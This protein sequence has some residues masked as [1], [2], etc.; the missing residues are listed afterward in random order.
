MKII[1]LLLI[2]ILAVLS[3]GLLSTY[4]GIISFKE[5]DDILGQSF[6]FNGKSARGAIAYGLA[7]TGGFSQENNSQMNSYIK[8]EFV[9]RLPEKMSLPTPGPIESVDEV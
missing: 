7:N 9:L 8:P 5:E 3:K 2:S 6:N 1:F 4:S